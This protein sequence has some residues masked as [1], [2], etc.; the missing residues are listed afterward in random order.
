M[1]DA[2]CG[3]CLCI[4]YMGLIDWVIITETRTLLR[5]ICL[6]LAYHWYWSTITAVE[7]TQI[8]QRWILRSC[9]A[10]SDRFVCLWSKTTKLVR[11]CD[12]NNNSNNNKNHSN[13]LTLESSLLSFNSLLLARTNSH[14]VEHTYMYIL[15]KIAFTFSQCFEYNIFHLSIE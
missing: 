12:N 6:L 4:W 10:H 9:E 7:F 3:V 2:L 11:E 14:C 1:I 15:S 8:S 13:P 5:G